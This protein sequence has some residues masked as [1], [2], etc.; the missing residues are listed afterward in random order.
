MGKIS[1]LRCKRNTENKNPKVPGTF[2]GRIM[3]QVT[4]L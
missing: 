2:N 4:V 3:F 1:I